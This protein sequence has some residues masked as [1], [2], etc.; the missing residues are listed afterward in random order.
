MIDC[1]VDNLSESDLNWFLIN[2][3]YKCCITIELIYAKELML[4]K[5]ITVTNA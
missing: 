5:V 1:L 2:G 3:F 4:L